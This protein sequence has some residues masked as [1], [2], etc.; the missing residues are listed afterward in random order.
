MGE[1]LNSSMIVRVKRKKS[2][3]D[4]MKRQISISISPELLE[5]IDERKGKMTRSE[6]IESTLGIFH[7]D[8]ISFWTASFNELAER[9][10]AHGVEIDWLVKS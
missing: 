5:K 4:K 3:G 2:L 7:R 8:K 6:A 10:R 1:P 9:A